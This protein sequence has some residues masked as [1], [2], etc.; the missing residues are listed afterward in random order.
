VIDKD[1]NLRCDGCN[2]KLGLHLQGYVEMVCPRCKKF[3][4]FDTNKLPK[5]Y[6]N[7]DNFEKVV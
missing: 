6:S 2:K 1:Q 3:N 5:E 7:L 4:I